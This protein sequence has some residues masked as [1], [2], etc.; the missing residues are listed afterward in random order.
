MADYGYDEKPGVKVDHLS[1]DKGLPA[2]KAGLKAGD[3]MTK[4]DGVDLKDVPGWMTVMSKYKPGDKVKVTYIR[5]GKEET[6]EATLVA[7]SGQHQ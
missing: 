2:E 4:W 6:T 1:S 3:L 5:D 7:P